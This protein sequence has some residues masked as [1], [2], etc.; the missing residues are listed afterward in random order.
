MRKRRERRWWLR[1]GRPRPPPREWR[2]CAHRTGDEAAAP[3]SLA[4]ARGAPSCSVPKTCQ[5]CPDLTSETMV[6]RGWRQR[7]ECW[8]GGG[9]RG[10]E[11]ELPLLGSSSARPGGGL[12]RR[13]PPEPQVLIW[14]SA[15]TGLLPTS[16]GDRR[17]GTSSA[18]F[19][20]SPAGRGRSRTSARGLDPRG[21]RPPPVSGLSLW[22]LLRWGR[23]APLG[24]PERLLLGAWAQCA[25]RGPLPSREPALPFRPGRGG[26][27]GEASPPSHRVS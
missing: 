13:H 7:R 5:V 1:L 3:T 16:C 26:A 20:D 2:R 14:G 10:D 24:R 6:S 12:Q 15:P 18:G 9:G 22:G 19:W 27:S 17:P 25:P 23:A 11:G 8:G 4:G 21:P